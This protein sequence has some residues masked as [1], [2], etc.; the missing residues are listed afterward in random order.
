MNNDRR[1]VNTSITFNYVILDDHNISEL[2]NKMLSRLKKN[3]IQINIF[4]KV[5]TDISK[6][7]SIRLIGKIKNGSKYF[8][9]KNSS[10]AKI[11]NIAKNFSNGDYV[12]FTKSDVILSGRV[13]N[14]IL[15]KLLIYDKE[16][17][18]VQDYMKNDDKFIYNEADEKILNL[19]LYCYFWSKKHIFNE[20]FNKSY[21]ID[22]DIDFIIRMVAKC[23]VKYP[24]EKIFIETKSPFSSDFYNYPFQYNAEWYSR[25]I[26]KVYIP[27][28]MIYKNLQFIQ[29]TILYLIQIRLAANRNNRNKNILTDRQIDKF[30]NACNEAV[31][32]INDKVISNSYFLNGKCLPRY[33]SYFLLKLKYEKNKSKEKIVIN[34]NSILLLFGSTK[35][36]D[37]E[38]IFLSIVAINREFGDIVIDFEVLN[39]YYLPYDDL[40]VI[41]EVNGD[42]I[43]TNHVEIYRLD[44]YFGRSF[45]KKYGGICSIKSSQFENG[46]NISFFLTYKNVKIKLPISFT[47]VSSRL[48]D[49]LNSCWIT[50]QY[51]LSYDNITR[52]IVISKK[53][54]AIRFINELIIFISL[55]SMLCKRDIEVREFLSVIV[56]RL[57]YWFSKPFIRNEIWITYDQLFKGGDNGETFFRYVKS[58]KLKDISI[59]YIINS[60][61]SDGIRL[62][63]EYN[64]I[65]PFKSFYSRLVALHSEYVFATRVDVKQYLGFDNNLEIY[66]RDLFTYRVLCLQHGLSIQKIAEYQNRIFDNTKY[67]FCV[68][69]LEIKNLK[70][71]AY[72]YNDNQLILTG[73]PRYDNLYNNSQKKIILIAPTWRRNVTAGT[74]KKGH[75]HDYSINFKHTDYYKI[76]NKLISDETLIN[77][78]LVNGYKILYVLHPNVSSQFSDFSRSKHVDI[79]KG[80][81]NSVNYNQ[82]LSEA[83]LLITDYSGIQYDFA[84]LRKPIV[85]Y[86]NYM[87]PPQYEADTFNYEING[88]GEIAKTHEDL[89]SILLEYIENKC[90]IKNIYKK[91][92]DMFFAYNDN[93]NCKRVFEA[94]SYIRSV[95]TK[96]N[97][98]HA[99]L[100]QCKLLGYKIKSKNKR[101]ESRINELSIRLSDIKNPFFIKGIFTYGIMLKWSMPIKST[102]T[103]IFRKN[104]D[105]SEYTLCIKKTDNSNT[106][107]D[108]TLFN[109]QLIYK[110]VHHLDKV[111]KSYKIIKIDPIDHVY[112]PT[113]LWYEIK[114]SKIN[115]CWDKLHEIDA[116]NI[117]ICTTQNPYSGNLKR[118]TKDH[119]Y[120][121]IDEISS[122]ILGY[123]VEYIV[124]KP[125]YLQFSGLSDLI[126]CPFRVKIINSNTCELEWDFFGVGILYEIWCR[127]VN[128]NSFINIGIFSSVNKFQ[129]TFNSSCKPM[130]YR[131]VG[132]NIRRDK[133][134][135]LDINM[136]Y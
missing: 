12:N 2:F 84:F 117:S 135:T 33:M 6:I 37:S 80:S 61:S 88:F 77:K 108:F 64:N 114:D 127:N 116:Y 96:L 26:G 130:T 81:S 21:E 107:T 56:L 104:G 100:Y 35:F 73:S 103:E 20:K 102:Y 85:Y 72:G 7:E 16:Y 14:K 70:H 19:S 5:N 83:S 134:F 93:F 74:N 42:I 69:P 52:Q 59:Y 34:K 87:L 136:I 76:Y 28:L 1:F 41:A 111:N 50:G 71:P 90:K 92:I 24:S 66:F 119:N 27:I 48:S 63:K 132:C 110:I 11:F 121:V 79:L 55:L 91:R 39:V 31:K 124:K 9:A 4:D 25:C 51:T 13:I 101:L 36:I 22:Y 17:L 125:K 47:K 97:S 126:Q 8:N 10:I 38:K 68:S 18:C 62:K 118:L 109:N 115:L 49:K 58:L 44:K 54:F 89:I 65:L 131:L 53:F 67:Y 120:Y 40:G 45:H 46:A 57:F 29:Y 129:H 23:Q 99:S 106:F 75:E 82:L 95:E 3:R 78:A 15:D 86:H 128:V 43:E 94:M 98:T 133:L 60:D 32:Y 105:S 112:K 122:R 30:F 123:K 113:A